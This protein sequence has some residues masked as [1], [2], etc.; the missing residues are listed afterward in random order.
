MK[1]IGSINRP[2]QPPD[3]RTV[4]LFGGL[5][6]AVYS[7]FNG[8]FAKTNKKLF[9][10][11]NTH[12]QGAISEL[13]A[14]STNVARVVEAQSQCVSTFPYASDAPAPTRPTFPLLPDESLR[15]ET[16]YVVIHPMS[17]A[18]KDISTSTVQ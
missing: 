14:T 1:L 6:D 5:G 9:V 10:V 18:D 7:L 2:R 4:E 12:H 8:P 16:K 15:P 3:Y 17:S 11:N 13:L